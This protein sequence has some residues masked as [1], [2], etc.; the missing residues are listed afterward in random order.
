MQDARLAECEQMLVAMDLAMWLNDGTAAIQAVVTCYGLLVPLI[1]H[2]I[3]CDTVVQV[4]NNLIYNIL[5]LIIPLI[6]IF[7]TCLGSD[8]QVLKRCLLVLEKNLGLL[9]QKWT[10][11]TSESLMHMIACI[12]YYLTKVCLHINMLHLFCVFMCE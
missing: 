10:G 8:V 11:N 5:L 12:T 9:K 4:F 1:F 2:Q 6:L 3:I 7:Y